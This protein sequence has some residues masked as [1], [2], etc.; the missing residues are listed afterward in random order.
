MTFNRH[1]EPHG[2]GES[3]PEFSD[4]LSMFRHACATTP[5]TPALVHRDRTWTYAEEASA[6]WALARRLHAASVHGRNVA[7]MIGNSPEYHVAFWAILAAGGIPCLFNVNYPAPALRPLFDDTDPRLALVTAESMEVTKDVAD[8]ERCA[9]IDLSS[10]ESTI[11][12]LVSD[13]V[14][15]DG[16]CP[17]ESDRALIMFSGGTTGGS[18]SIPHTHRAMMDSV[19]R[20]E[21]GWPTP[22]RG[23]VWL[24]VAPFF[25][26]YGFLHGVANPVFGRA[27]IVVPERFQPDHVVDLM[28]K[29]RVTVFGGGPPAIYNALLSAEN[30]DSTDLSTL[31]SCPAGGAPFPVELLRRWKERSGIDIFEGYGMT[32]I[33]PLTVNTATFGAKAGTVGTA[34]PDV[35]VEI[36]EIGHR[37]RVLAP[38]QKGE[39]RVKGPHLFAAYLNRPDDTAAAFTDGYLYTGDVGHLDEDG[40]L[41]ISDRLKDVIFVKGFNV[42]PREVEEVLTNHPAVDAVGVVGIPHDRTDE[43]VIAFV[44]PGD[45]EPDVERLQQHCAEHLVAY[46]QPAHIHLVDR[47]PLTGARKLDRM[48][49]RRSALDLHSESASV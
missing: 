23:D 14:D 36:T 7:L 33:A 39:I 11:D 45:A 10:P 2:I 1:P 27:S 38:G 18:K 5:D 35:D 16:Y 40:F 21:W 24:P 31:R 3:R 47:L 12:R 17:G 46:K 25:H 19:R 42:F 30:F 32:E 29:H 34:A 22:A 6:V 41:T 28:G 48:A 13:S 4:L 15:D 37:D 8:T 49:L 44:T 26:I 9:I 20:M 43:Q